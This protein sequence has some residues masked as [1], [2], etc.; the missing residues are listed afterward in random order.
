MNKKY[1]LIT[2]CIFT[3]IFVTL[4]SYKIILNTTQLTPLQQ[5]SIDF[6]NGEGTLPQFE[7][8]A[9]SHMQDVKNVFFY[10]D[11]IF[12]VSLFF[13]TLMITYY[14][15]DKTMFQKIFKYGGWTTVIGLSVIT[16]FSLISFN[17]LFTLFHK[18]FFPQGN[19]QFPADSLLIQTFPI[20]FFI[21]I[22]VKTFLLTIVFG[23]LFILGGNYLKHVHGKRT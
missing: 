19:W 1:I 17:T 3:L 5:Q 4:L 2:F 8:N 15:S 13:L 18:I 7:E 12:Y 16:L 6:L 21:G 22:A 14:Q 23:I 11:V 9:V 10:V 20:E